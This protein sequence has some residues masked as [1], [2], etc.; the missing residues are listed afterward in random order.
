MKRSRKE[1]DRDRVFSI[2]LQH[3]TPE[4]AIG[5]QELSASSCMPES[6]VR[7]IIFEFAA[8]EHISI[9]LA[10]FPCRFYYNEKAEENGQQQIP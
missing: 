6:E 2:L 8:K 3:R 4:D 5:L 1:K 9:R 10:G 7:K